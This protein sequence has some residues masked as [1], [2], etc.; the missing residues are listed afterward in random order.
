MIKIRPILFAASWGLAIILPLYFGGAALGAR[1]GLWDWRFAL[2]KLFVQYGPVLLI[3]SAFFGLLALLASLIFSPRRGR[4]AS[5]IAL[6]IPLAGL[7]YGR[8]IQNVASKTPPIHDIATDWAPAI[9]FSPTLLAQ[10][11]LGA[12]RVASDG[13]VPVDHPNADLRGQHYADIIRASYPDLSPIVMRQPVGLAY[14]LVLKEVKKRGWKVVTANRDAGIIEA[15]STSFWF[16]FVDDIA[17][18]LHMTEL[19]ARIDMR[20]VSRVG[21]SDLGA[22]AA[23]IASFEKALGGK[24]V[25][26]P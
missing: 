9:A 13:L 2:G 7:G 14:D 1:F 26:K 11:G 25:A 20:S 18:V 5:A 3:A 19:G 23:R 22:N 10:R 15:S 12:N 6:L 8:H 24:P 17:I 21:V 4:I 16:G